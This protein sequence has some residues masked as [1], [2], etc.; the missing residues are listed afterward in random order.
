MHSKDSIHSHLHNHQPQDS[1]NVYSLTL[2]KRKQKQ[3]SDMW[4]AQV[5]LQAMLCTA[6]VCTDNRF[7][8]NLIISKLFSYT[9]SNKLI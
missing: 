2:Y 3:N 8:H 5:V 6:S 1:T 4:E 7:V 9:C